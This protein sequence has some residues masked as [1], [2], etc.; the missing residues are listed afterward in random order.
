MSLVVL[1]TAVAIT[2][3]F[4][5]ITE[6]SYNQTE[7]TDGK[8]IEASYNQTEDTDDLGENVLEI[9]PDQMQD[10]FRNPFKPLVLNEKQVK[11]LYNGGVFSKKDVE[12]ERKLRDSLEEKNKETNCDS[13]NN[14]EKSDI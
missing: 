8:I 5:K 7:G 2:P 3:S 6:A 14:E 10:M 11:K 4:E 1:F 9:S 12:K 13:F